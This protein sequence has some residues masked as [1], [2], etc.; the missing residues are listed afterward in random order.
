[1]KIKEVPHDFLNSFVLETESAAMELDHQDPAAACA[2]FVLSDWILKYK[3]KLLED[4]QQYSVKVTKAERAALFC[5]FGLEQLH[6]NPYTLQFIE[7]L[8]QLKQ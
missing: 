5:V 3:K 1:M 2:Y 6:P 7:Q 8:K 4:K